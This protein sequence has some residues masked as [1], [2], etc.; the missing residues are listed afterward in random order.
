MREIEQRGKLFRLYLPAM[1]GCFL[2]SVLLIGCTSQQ[3][4]AP[5]AP[6]V[7][8]VV[9]KVEK[10]NVPLELRAIG[11]VEAL[12]SVSLKSQVTGPVVAV[13][14]REGQDVRKGDPLFEIDRRPFE[15]A[16]QQAQADLARDRAKAE[17]ARVD[18]DR[19]LKL[20]EQNITPK[21]QYDAQRANADALD[22]AVLADK[23]AIESAK[24]NLQY[25]LI[26]SPLD[27]RT[28]NVLVKPG[29]LA[30]AN[31]VP[32]LVTINQ[33]TPIY[34]NFGVP[35]QSL[36]DVK[37]YDTKRTLRVKAL[38]PGEDGVTEEG[39]LSFVDNAVDSTT[40]MIRLKASFSNGKRRLWPGQY[41]TVVLT[42]TTQPN[43]LVV[44][45]QAINTGQSGSFVYIIKSDNTAELRGVTPGRTVGTE[46]IV[47]SGL[48]PGETVV[49][50]GQLRIVSGSKVMVKPAS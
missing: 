39:N 33:I 26:R 42:L 8:V 22:A 48:L 19:Y 36:A 23:A 45:S 20:F 29:N 18:A 5:A 35:E 41:V 4:A 32:I 21:Q 37:R 6:A 16:L 12:A 13:H 24:L 38:V 46:T 25:C 34:V 40:G 14:F 49:T 31:D 44:P 47:E 27:G 1:A 10:K 43:A 7:P 11:N 3:A 9:A 15:V 17:N 30:K 50:D 2:A 28:G